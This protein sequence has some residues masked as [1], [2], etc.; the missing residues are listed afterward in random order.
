[1]NAARQRDGW[2]GAFRSTRL[3]EELWRPF[4]F[5]GLIAVL[6]VQWPSRPIA[7]PPVALA[8]FVVAGVISLATL[9]PWPEMPVRWLFAAMLGYMLVSALLLPL[10]Q[11]TAA[12]VFAFAAAGIAGERLP[13]ARLAF[14]VAVTGGIVSVAGTLLVNVVHPMGSQWW[15]GLL[16]P[17]PV[18][19]GVARRAREDAVVAAQRAGE[20]EAREAALL[21]RGRIAREIHD[22]LGHSLSGIAMQL[23]MADALHGKGRDDEANAAV[24]RARA[25]AVDSISDTRRAIEALREDT[26]P[27]ERTLALLATNEA[28]PFSVE[29][30]PVPLPA[31]VTHA[32]LRAAQEALVN[33][34][35]HAAGAERA[36]ALRFAPDRVGLTVT[37]G[38]GAGAPRQAAGGGMGLVGMRERIA[39]VGG[40]VR[41]GPCG[42]GWKV[43]LE[44]PV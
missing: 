32:V 41:A 38:P 1:M 4:L 31:E 5:L 3:T 27:L 25:L 24:R 28:V 40:T 17:A 36:M 22:V 39:L 23:D 42:D 16:V 14:T 33:A 18:F 9:F 2:I 35:K 6:V 19:A 26:L 7:L 8:L 10:A 15:V 37:N 12:P 20:S 21:E 13:S 44:V 43:E 11:S 34:A 30:S 29:G